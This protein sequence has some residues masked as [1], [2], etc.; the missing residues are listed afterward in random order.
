M[1]NEAVAAHRGGDP[2]LEE[3][4]RVARLLRA[5]LHGIVALAV[6]VPFPIDRRT[7]T[8]TADD[9]LTLALQR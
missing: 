5:S 8:E 6:S 4:V 9:L 3:N 1:W 7:M 2:R